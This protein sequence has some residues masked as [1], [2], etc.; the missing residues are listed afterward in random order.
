MQITTAIT[1]FSFW[2]AML[3]IC[4]YAFA[5]GG[6]PERLGAAISL[7]AWLLT[8]MMRVA[9]ASAWLPAALSILAID[10]AVAVGFFWLAVTT[11]R[12]WPIWACGFAFSNLLMSVAGA[13]LPRIELFAYHTGLGAYAYLA[14][15]ALALGTYRLPRDADPVV[16]HG[17]R[18]QWQE[19]Q[20]NRN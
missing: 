13:L 14:L 20:N 10:I 2:A 7:A 19:T 3:G 15:G 17:A 12:F 1:V 18:V 9:F 4:G 8:M 6:R 11:T 5:C 16:R